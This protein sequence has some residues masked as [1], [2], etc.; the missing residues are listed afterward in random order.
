MEK[1]SIS[2]EVGYMSTSILEEIVKEYI[3]SKTKKGIFTGDVNY[4]LKY[5][6]LKKYN[7]H[8]N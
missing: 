6:E 8:E 5:Q 3:G 4:L 2:T 1:N 7:E